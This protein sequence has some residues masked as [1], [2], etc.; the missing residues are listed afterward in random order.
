MKRIIMAAA[1]MLVTCAT[2]AEGETKFAVGIAAAFSDYE[3]DS[4][5]P[6]ND[7]GLGL[8]LFAQVRANP[9]FAIEGGYYNSGDFS[10]EF[11]NVPA[12]DDGKYEM[13]LSGFNVSA[14]GI[15]P[16]SDGGLELYGKLGL[17]D[18]DINLTVP[19]GNSQRPDSL[20]HE[21]GVFGG[22]GVVLNIGDNIGIRTEVIYYDISNADLW[23]LNMGVQIGF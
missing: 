20:G 1:L 19:Q 23:S 8:Q 9:W 10:S 16:L 11:V 13:S 3:G 5:F 15:F 7:S 22:A 17:Y 2:Y 12:L 4:S 6:V 14:L 18:Y 21:S